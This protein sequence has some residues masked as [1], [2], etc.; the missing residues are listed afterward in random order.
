[1]TAVAR[2][3]APHRR[4]RLTAIEEIC[5]VQVTDLAPLSGPWAMVH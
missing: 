2:V 4:P 1:M 3:L 5:A